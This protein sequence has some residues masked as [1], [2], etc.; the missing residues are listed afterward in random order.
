MKLRSIQALAALA[1]LAV[2]LG[3][4]FP[5]PEPGRGHERERGFERGPEREFPR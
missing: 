5:R 2:G 4:L 1:V 3:C